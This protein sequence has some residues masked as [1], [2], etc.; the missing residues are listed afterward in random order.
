MGKKFKPVL[1][2]GVR[3]CIRSKVTSGLL[4]NNILRL[5]MRN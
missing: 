3:L 2:E 4:N 1:N 5:E